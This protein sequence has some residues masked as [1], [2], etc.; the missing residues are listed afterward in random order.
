MLE[1]NRI[2]YWYPLSVWVSS[3]VFVGPILIAISELKIDHTNYHKEYL[4]SFISF[5]LL[6]MLFAIPTLAAITIAFRILT[7]KHMRSSRLIIILDSIYAIGVFI[8][9]KCVHWSIPMLPIIIYI[10]AG[11]ISSLL[12]KVYKREKEI[13]EIVSKPT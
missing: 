12:F 9:L 11:I 4:L 7:Q 2:N 8:T 6:T 5:I 13:S 10:L 1:S 3:I